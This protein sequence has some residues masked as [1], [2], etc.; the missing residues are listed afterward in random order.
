MNAIIRGDNKI[1]KRFSFDESEYTLVF[2]ARQLVERNPFAWEDVIPEELT[3]SLYGQEYVVVFHSDKPA[4]VAVLSHIAKG[5]LTTEV[6]NITITSGFALHQS[7]LPDNSITG[8]VYTDAYF[9]VDIGGAFKLTG[10]A[11]TSFKYDKEYFGPASYTHSIDELEKYV[12]GGG[13]NTFSLVNKFAGDVFMAKTCGIGMS[14]LICGMEDITDCTIDV[15]RKSTGNHL[16]T[17]DVPS[18]E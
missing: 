4:N 1:K 17:V 9:T 13:T 2:S 18:E 5:Y 3:T 7:D 15:Y 16:V 8:V 6:N 12:D 14:L 11:N 10:T